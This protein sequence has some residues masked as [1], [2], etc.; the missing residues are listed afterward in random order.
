MITS[1]Q[2][3]GRPG[4]VQMSNLR[5]A[6]LP[7]PSVIRSAKIATIQASDASK[8]GRVPA[9]KLRQVTQKLMRESGGT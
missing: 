7:V 2:H 6:G 4:D 3:R 1:A 5:M 8:L 9:A